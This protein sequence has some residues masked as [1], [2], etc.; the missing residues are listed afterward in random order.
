MPCEADGVG[1]HSGMNPMVMIIPVV[2]LA[3]GILC[4]LLLPVPLPIRLAV[5]A[6]DA[7]AASVIGFVLARRLR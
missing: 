5:L 2:I 7:I 1:K 6:S 4:F 3:G